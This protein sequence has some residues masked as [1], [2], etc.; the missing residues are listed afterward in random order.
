MWVKLRRFHLP[1][2]RQCWLSSLFS[3]QL[4]QFFWT[5]YAPM[6]Y[7]TL[8]NMPGERNNKFFQPDTAAATGFSGRFI[9][10]RCSCARKFFCRTGFFSVLSLLFLPHF[11]HAGDASSHRRRRLSSEV[12]AYALQKF[13]HMGTDL[14]KFLCKVAVT[15]D[16]YANII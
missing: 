7:H 2:D 15:C 11:S 13:S 3:N 14:F 16:I 10:L 4:R 1:D 8:F 5:E 9:V 6:L 12:F